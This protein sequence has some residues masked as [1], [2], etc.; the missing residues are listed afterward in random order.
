MMSDCVDVKVLQWMDTMERRHQ[1]Q[2]SLAPQAR[3]LF[4]ET[5]GLELWIPTS[6]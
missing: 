2:A 5:K 3:P 1:N 6:F 4:V